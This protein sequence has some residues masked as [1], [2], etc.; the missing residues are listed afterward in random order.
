MTSFSATNR[1]SA[2]LKSSRQDIWDALTDPELLP[3]LTP[4][5]HRID[6]EGDRWT[7]HVAK[8]PLMGKS[9]GTCFTE[10]MS[11]DEPSRISYT[12][13]QARKDEPTAVDGEYHLK[14]VSEGTD[15]SIALTVSSELPF[16]R[17]VRRHVGGDGRDGPA[18]R[19]QPAAPPRREVSRG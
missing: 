16:P 12:H 3:E 17:F 9:I 4:Y 19:P 2:T 8:V 15:V 1:S 10:I 5:L 13:D 6:V 14:E 18:L 11:F 7:W